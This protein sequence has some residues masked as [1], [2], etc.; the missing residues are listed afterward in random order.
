VDVPTHA[1]QA[2][3]GDACHRSVTEAGLNWYHIR[4]DLAG[5]GGARQLFSE[6]SLATDGY[7]A[8]HHPAREWLTA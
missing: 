8:R 3:G 4:D 5:F 7:A 6:R 2:A 1:R